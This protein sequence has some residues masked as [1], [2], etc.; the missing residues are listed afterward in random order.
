VLRYD[1]NGKFL[2]RFGGNKDVPKEE[3]LNNAH[4]IAIDLRQGADKSTVLVTS[5]PDQCFRR[6]TMEGKY[7]ETISVPGA[8]VCRPVISG[9]ELYAGVCWSKDPV[10]SKLPGN[11]S[12]FTVILDAANKVVSA[13]GGTAPV[14]ENGALKPLMRGEPVIDHGH[15]VCVLDNGDLI[16]CQWNAFQTY[17]IKLERL[18]A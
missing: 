16:V 18:A 7:I 5:R 17:P 15:D 11:P 12:G 1:A 8:L 10:A 6:F 3:A 14:Y 4:G 13:P 2:S 9:Q